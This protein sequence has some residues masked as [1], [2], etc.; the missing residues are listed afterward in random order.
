MQDAEVEQVVGKAPIRSR[1]KS[2]S[3][4]VPHL[5]EATASVSSSW[6]SASQISGRPKRY[7]AEKKSEDK[8]AA[9]WEKVNKINNGITVRILLKIN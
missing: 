6:S 7:T 3:F 8:F 1:K 5:S 9:F 4:D 2:V